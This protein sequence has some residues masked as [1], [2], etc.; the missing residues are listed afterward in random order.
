M[1][2]SEKYRDI[3]VMKS[4]GASNRGVA[5]IFLFYGMMLGNIGCVLGTIAGLVI[6][7]YINEIEMF[8]ARQSGTQI[9]DRSIYYFDKIPTNIEP[10]NIIVINIGAIA[11]AIVFS[12]LPAIRAARLQPVRALRFE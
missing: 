6:T 10:W 11:T 5:G 1:I 7:H 3:G 4:L 9:F 8:I 12:L 2:V